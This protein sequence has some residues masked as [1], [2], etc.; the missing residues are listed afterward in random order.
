MKIE[1]NQ[2]SLKQLVKKVSVRKV[3]LQYISRYWPTI[4][5]ISDGSYRDL[6]LLS[7]SPRRTS[8]LGIS[9]LSFENQSSRRRRVIPPP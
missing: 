7:H 6:I 5:K 9:S 8:G 2:Y 1:I 4:N 3:H